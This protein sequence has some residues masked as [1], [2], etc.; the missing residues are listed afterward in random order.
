[1]YNIFYIQYVL[2]TIYYMYN[3]FYVQY[4]LCT[5]YSMYN[6]ARPFLRRFRQQI[7]HFLYQLVR[8]FAEYR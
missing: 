1:M 6:H 7:L 4:I 5:I 8:K 2:C 3:I